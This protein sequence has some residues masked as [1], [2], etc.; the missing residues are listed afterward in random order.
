MFAMAPNAASDAGLRAEI[1]PLVQ[2]IWEA[3]R[4][5]DIDAHNALLTED[6]TAI[7]PD[8]SIHPRPTREQI[9]AHPLGTFSLTEF[10]AAQIGAGAA[11]V[12]YLADVR[13][14]ASNPVRVRYRVGEL[15][16][17]HGPQW[18]CRS[19]QPTVLPAS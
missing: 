15:W 8:G 10:S 17:K 5:G 7:H 18:K 1:E 13:G 19:Y 2:R 14:P 16:V 11:L 6:Y 4:V 3:Y 12:N 9:L